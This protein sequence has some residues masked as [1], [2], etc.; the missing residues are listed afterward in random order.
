MTM[1]KAVKRD[2]DVELRARRET[3]NNTLGEIV[4]CAGRVDEDLIEPVR[5]VLEGGGKRLRPALVLWC[6]EV[7]SGGVND[8]ARIAAAAIEMVH[9]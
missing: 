4:N 6:C 7:V 9:T 1:T 5:Y 2:F 3:V 8:D